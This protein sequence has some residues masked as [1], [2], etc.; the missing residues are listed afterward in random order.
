MTRNAETKQ[1]GFYKVDTASGTFSRLLEE[2]KTYGGMYRIL[3]LDVSSDMKRMIF[4]S[5]SGQ[6]CED[7]WMVDGGF[8]QPVRVT[9]INPHLRRYLMGESRVIEW[10]GIDG[11]KQRGALLL[12]A[13]YKSTLRY[14]LVVCQY[15]GERKSDLV[16]NYGLGRGHAVDNWQLLATRGYA[17]LLPDISPCDTRSSQNMECISR[18]VLS[19]VDKVIELGIA[20]P[21]KLGLIGHSYGGYGVLSLLV[22]TARFRAAVSR[23]PGYVNAFSQY[24]NLD[25]TGDSVYVELLEHY[26]GGSPWER[27]NQ[28]IENSPFFYLDRVRTPLLLVQGADD[29]AT[30]A[31]ETDLIFVSLRR[32][33]QE[34]EYAKYEGEGHAETEWKY[35][36]QVDYLNRILKWFDS[37]LK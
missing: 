16:N 35:V 20:D 32:L 24:G 4:C 18:K 1:S 8:S 12:P 30:R 28:Y 10:S 22:Q 29:N 17:V 23:A 26:M 7:L 11:S 6:Q 5:Q 3:T 14:P 34:V 31:T 9:D 33:G 19:G 27:R 2:D 15:P 36:N 13:G 21:D 37:K 25:R